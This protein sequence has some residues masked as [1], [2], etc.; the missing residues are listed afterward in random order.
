[1]TVIFNLACSGSSCASF[2]EMI[3]LKMAE[4]FSQFKC[5]TLVCTNNFIHNQH[6]DLSK[7]ALV[8]DTVKR[9]VNPGLTMKV[10]TE[11]SFASV[12]STH[13]DY[14]PNGITCY[15]SSESFALYGSS[16]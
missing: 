3:A 12:N 2:N 9:E 16:N 8:Q 14:R 13:M 7:T 15:T 10:S 5:T 6:Y 1:M 11:N 4:V